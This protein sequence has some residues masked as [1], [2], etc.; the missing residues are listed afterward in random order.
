MANQT[1]EHFLIH[2]SPAANCNPEAAVRVTRQEIGVHSNV[3]ALPDERGSCLQKFCNFFSAARFYHSG[4][5]LRVGTGGAGLRI[6]RL[7]I[8][9]F[10]FRASRLQFAKDSLVGQH[11]KKG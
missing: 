3:A 4:S 5:G 8:F 6:P 1:L 11:F 10:R 7:Q 2:S 9:I